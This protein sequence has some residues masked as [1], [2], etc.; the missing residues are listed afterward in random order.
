MPIQVATETLVVAAIETKLVAELPEAYG[1]GAG[2]A[3]PS[4]AWP[5]CSRGRSGAAS[6]R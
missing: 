1:V 5:T 6:I 4:A 3:A 2:A